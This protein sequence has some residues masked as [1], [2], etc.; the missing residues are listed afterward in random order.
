MVCMCDLLVVTRFIL[1]A[2]FMYSESL[3]FISRNFILTIHI[4]LSSRLVKDA[5]VGEEQFIKP[6][7]VDNA[8][9]LDVEPASYPFYMLV[10]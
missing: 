7:A 1:L 9:L 2:F 8:M 6:G 10:T 5:D 3:T 4:T